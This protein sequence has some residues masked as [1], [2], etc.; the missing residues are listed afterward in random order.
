MTYAQGQYRSVNIAH[1]SISGGQQVDIVRTHDNY[2]PPESFFYLAFLGTSQPANVTVNS[3][4][5][6][7]IIRPTPEDA[8][9]ELSK[10]N[11]NAT[12]Y[13]ANIKTT[14]VKVFDN[15][16]NLQIIAVW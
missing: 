7:N 8:A 10:S 4:E 5:V 6:L 1:R 11:S 16:Q 13:N 2:T 14:F 9:G 12:Y 15:A 3:Q